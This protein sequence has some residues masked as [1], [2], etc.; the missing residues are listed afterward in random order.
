[1]TLKSRTRSLLRTHCELE[2]QLKA[3]S[4]NSLDRKDP[5]NSRAFRPLGQPPAKLHWRPK[6]R[7]K[8][9]KKAL[10][11]SGAELEQCWSRA[12]L[13]KVHD[14]YVH[15]CLPS[16]DCPVHCWVS[17]RGVSWAVCSFEDRRGLSDVLLIRFRFRRCLKRWQKLWMMM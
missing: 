11:D 13:W 6:L 5:K 9:R 7:Q 8:M 14:G 17:R 15:C 2:R 1:M 10:I 4:W 12:K 16:G 3:R